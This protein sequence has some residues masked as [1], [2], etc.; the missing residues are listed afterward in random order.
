M[1]RFVPNVSMGRVPFRNSRIFSWKSQKTL[2]K[3]FRGFCKLFNI[4]ISLIKW[5]YFLWFFRK[6]RKCPKNLLGHKSY[7]GHQLFLF[8]L[9]EP[10]WLKLVHANPFACHSQSHFDKYKLILVFQAGQMNEAPCLAHNFNFHENQGNYRLQYSIWV[11]L[12]K[13]HYKWDKI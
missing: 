6:H 3:E 2:G 4:C 13:F 1:K 11:Y 12:D 5:P 7:D 10:V 9:L 8:L